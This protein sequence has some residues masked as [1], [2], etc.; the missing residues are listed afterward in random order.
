MA[1]EVMAEERP[2]TLCLVSFE[3]LILDTER[4]MRKLCAWLGV[5]YLPCL[6]QP[7]WFGELIDPAVIGVVNDDFASFSRTRDAVLLKKAFAPLRDE[8]LSEREALR[9]A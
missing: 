7:T 1:A 5:D 6:R 9:Q 8:V 3:E 2:D 4:V